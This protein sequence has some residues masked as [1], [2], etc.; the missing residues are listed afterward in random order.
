MNLY[1]LFHQL[2]ITVANR[3]VKRFRLPVNNFE[4]P[5]SIKKPSGINLKAFVGEG[6]EIEH[7]PSELLEIEVFAN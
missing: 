6:I 2:L 3:L 1:L 4:R 7:K 5:R